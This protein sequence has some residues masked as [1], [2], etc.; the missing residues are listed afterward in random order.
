MLHRYNRFNIVKKGPA[1][2]VP[3]GDWTSELVPVEKPEV[4]HETKEKKRPSRRRNA[5]RIELPASKAS[6]LSSIDYA[7][8]ST[9][10]ERAIFRRFRKH[11]TTE[12]FRELL[13]L[14]FPLC[15][16]VAVRFATKLPNHINQVE[17]YVSVGLFGLADAILA[18]DPK[19]KARFSTYAGRRILGAM[20]DE[21]RNIDWVSR[22][23][24]HRAATYEAA[25]NAFRSDNGREPD[26]TELIGMFPQTE[27]SNG[28]GHKKPS[29]LNRIPKMQHISASGMAEQR[30]RDG[31]RER[32]GATIRDWRVENPKAVAERRDYLEFLLGCLHPFVVDIMRRYFFEEETMAEIGK[33]VDLSE[34]RIS[35]IVK[36]SLLAMRQLAKRQEEGHLRLA[37]TSSTD[38]DDSVELNILERRSND[39]RSLDDLFKALDDR[40]GNGESV[41]VWKDDGESR[42]LDELRIPPPESA[43]DMDNS[44]PIDNSNLRPAMRRPKVEILRF[45]DGLEGDDDVYAWAADPIQNEQIRTGAAGPSGHK[46]PA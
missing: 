10:D 33:A 40:N 44:E 26:F 5:H 13:T 14:Y 43:R 11:P 30:D 2:A 8:L 16:M 18:Y 46:K 32:F 41:F 22:T 3:V 25:T 9:C 39:G 42:N 6:S 17:D 28:N 23:A 29:P 27:G 45:I 24:R 15:Q 12:M 21:Q 35:Q 31:E 4:K 20:Q 1:T 38:H 19:R 7:T 37:L 34:S 36:F